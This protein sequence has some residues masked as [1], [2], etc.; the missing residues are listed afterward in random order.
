[1]G[2]E[3]HAIFE[4]GLTPGVGFVSGPVG[5]Q[6]QQTALD[7]GKEAHQ[8]VV[9]NIVGKER[10]G[11]TSLRKMLT[12]D[13][14]DM[15][16]ISTVGIEQK[17]VDTSGLTE[18]WKTVDVALSNASEFEEALGVHTLMRLKPSRKVSAKNAVLASCKCFLKILLLV[19]GLLSAYLCVSIRLS[20][21]VP[22][23]GF[24]LVLTY[25]V[26]VCFFGLRDGFGIAIGVIILAL[27]SDGVCRWQ[28]HEHFEQVSSDYGLLPALTLGFVLFFLIDS[29]IGLSCGMSLGTGMTL[30]LCIMDTPVAT[31]SQPLTCPIGLYHHQAIFMLSTC[32]GLGTQKFPQVI[33][34]IIVPALAIVASRAAET[35]SSS[36]FT[37]VFGLGCGYGHGVFLS[38]GQKLYLLFKER[39]SPLCEPQTRRLITYAIGIIPGLGFSFMLGWRFPRN[40]NLG[41]HVVGL[42]F[43]IGVELLHLINSLKRSPQKHGNDKFK[44][45]SLSPSK[46][47][48]ARH[49]RRERVKLVMRDY[50]GHALY[51]SVHHIFMAAHSI[52]LVVFNL[53]DAVLDA[54]TSLNSL[55]FWLHSIQVHAQYPNASVLIVGTHRDHNM[56][57]PTKVREIGNFLRSSLPHNLHKFLIWNEDDTPLFPVENS[58]RSVN[59]ADHEHLRKTL[60]RIA[61]ESEFQKQ[62]WPIKY[63]ALHK[64]IQ[65][66]RENGQ[67]IGNFVE[68]YEVCKKNQCHIK[69]EDEFKD[70]LNFFHFI[71]EIIYKANGKLS[72][73]IVFDPQ[74]L[75]NIMASIVTIP[76]L[77]K[78]KHSLMDDWRNLK[79][80][81]TLSTPLLQHLLSDLTNANVQESLID[82]LQHY[83]LICKVMLNNNGFHYIVPKLL[84][85][86]KHLSGWW[87]DDV[88]SD[89]I[90][91]VDFGCFP[92][93]TIFLRLVCQC[94]QYDNL[95][96]IAVPRISQSAALFTFENSYALKLELLGN[97]DFVSQQSQMI[98]VTVRCGRGREPAIVL[99]AIQH[100]LKRIVSQDFEKCS[101]VFGPKCPFQDAHDQENSDIH[102]LEIWSMNTEDAS[103]SRKK[104][105]TFWCRGRMIELQGSKAVGL[106]KTATSDEKKIFQRKK[107][108]LTAKCWADTSF[109]SLTPD[110]YYRVCNALNTPSIFGRDWKGLA[111]HLGKSMFEVQ[112]LERQQNPCD[113]VLTEWCQTSNVT[114]S[115]VINC[116]RDMGRLDLVQDIQNYARE[117]NLVQAS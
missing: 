68:L 106:D 39:V 30:T 66:R 96:N 59:D 75:V 47:L 115:D 112:V 33:S 77:S 14:F 76:S 53:K 49:R 109:K 72:D 73:V 15:N 93:Q 6:A 48:Q 52:Y 13:P 31:D 56:V 70:M 43:V 85:H 88:D 69:D 87:D 4:M 84:P 104:Q 32:V 86:T 44:S 79:N 37:L 29:Y 22:W 113:A 65:K 55:L 102:L 18:S 98:K 110:I 82:L 40:F 7:E 16:E 35:Q 74:L 95:R 107:N 3:S 19:A 11:K 12:C 50:A 45:T 91:Y 42:T 90:Y 97:E 2:D 60:M 21:Q 26:S 38:V 83:H 111:A 1:M 89:I 17:L 80:T 101:Y 67:L 64:V 20:D 92:P 9:V 105:T 100:N 116:L 46:V 5:L 54:R 34:W 36:I 28:L 62:L 63:L 114:V 57:G 24:L 41:K 71:G 108:D 117:H 81:G 25:A 58:L 8:R 99:D 78:Q 23:M 27:W 51:H 94:V 61:R 10:Q 103:A